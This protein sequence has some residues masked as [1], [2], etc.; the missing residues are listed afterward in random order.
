[1]FE[2]LDDLE[3]ASWKL[4]VQQISF[5]AVTESLVIALVILLQL[6]YSTYIK[7]RAGDG[8]LHLAKTKVLGS[9]F[10]LPDDEYL[11]FSKS[12][13]LVN[14]LFSGLT[15][16]L[17]ILKTQ[18]LDVDSW[19]IQL[20]IV[21]TAFF[22]LHFLVNLVRSEFSWDYV[23]SCSG[24]IDVF[25]IVVI[26]VQNTH[27]H[28]W[29]SWS[30]FRMY[31][32]YSNYATL[33]WLGWNP[34]N[35]HEIR[36]HLTLSVFKF[37]AV[38]VIMSGSVFVVEVLGDID[39][40]DEKMIRVRMGHVSFYSIF[41]MV[42]ITVSTVG[43][44]DLSPT[45]LLGRFL[46]MGCIIYGV[47][48]FSRESAN[49]V[50]IRN[51]AN[52]GSGHY[53][54]RHKGKLRHV[55]V[56]GDALESNSTIELEM[57]LQELFDYRKLESSKKDSKGFVAALD[58]VFLSRSA[59]SSALQALLNKRATY[60]S[61]VHL[62]QGSVFS[63]NDLRRCKFKSCS[64]FFVL[65]SMNCSNPDETDERGILMTAAMLKM[66]PAT[67]FQLVLLR[68]HSRMLAKRFNIPQVNCFAMYEFKANLLAQGVRCPGLSTILFHLGKA[69][70]DLNISKRLLDAHPW[71]SEYKEGALHQVIATLLRD[72]YCG[73]T[74]LECALKVYE[75][76][77]ALLIAFSLQGR[78]VT[79]PGKA[80]TVTSSTVVYLIAKSKDQVE[81]IVQPGEDWKDAFG[82]LVRDQQ[83]SR[84]P[85]PLFKE[86]RPS[87]RPARVDDTAARVAPLPGEVAPS[88][89]EGVVK[90]RNSTWDLKLQSASTFSSFTLHNLDD[91]SGSVNLKS[92]FTEED[93]G[94]GAELRA[95]H[96]LQMLVTKVDKQ[97]KV[98]QAVQA[99]EA[100]GEK[101]KERREKAIFPALMMSTRG[102]I[103]VLATGKLL[104]QQIAAF[105]RPLRSKAIL[106]WREIVVVSKHELPKDMP[107]FR[108]VHYIN[109]DP[110]DFH[111]LAL[112][113]VEDAFKIVIL[114][115]YRP[116]S[117]PHL[118]DQNTVLCNG[119]VESYL[120]Q[121]PQSSA[122][123][124]TVLSNP[125]SIKQL[126]QTMHRESHPEELPRF[127]DMKGFS[128]SNLEHM[129]SMF[130]PKKQLDVLPPSLHPQ[131]VSGESM[132]LTQMM[133]W[134]ASEFHTPG[135]VQLMEALMSPENGDGGMMPSMLWMMHASQLPE[136]STWDQ[137]ATRCMSQGAI[138]IAAHRSMCI[139]DLGPSQSEGTG[140]FV[141]TNPSPDMLLW[142]GRKCRSQEQPAPPPSIWRLPSAASD[143]SDSAKD[144]YNA[145][146]CGVDSLRYLILST[147]RLRGG[148]GHGRTGGGL[149]VPLRGTGP[150]NVSGSY[151]DRGKVESR[152]V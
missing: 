140:S 27:Q 132:V 102:H 98:L 145:C 52:R 60:A 44:G 71:I 31:S 117:E 45:T 104:E 125:H 4:V 5:F 100:A 113:A 33:V 43:Y 70:Q 138:P 64:M 118:M 123:I 47:V 130:V 50:A 144:R 49:I 88:Q 39:G 24:V 97:V 135:F 12:L 59:P 34:L 101:A 66:F 25:T 48:F 149:P 9:K 46:I 152:Q 96:A 115:A 62:L 126:A 134:V 142:P 80:V 56:V 92:R 22:T 41:Y 17:W 3:E 129:G 68:P 29:L 114:D 8:A 86:K 74:F 143:G 75:K 54:S 95:K 150:A 83:T 13:S 94:R 79:N 141:M 42:M 77:R 120:N 136:C 7:T 121:F 15:V 2:G 78:I 105:I 151:V 23:L 148:P 133:G 18:R 109:A 103:V 147:L 131:F 72:E 99:L 108:G 57:V 30:Y 6:F 28:A 67:P 85:M 128:M 84:R 127:L 1:M 122:S 32:M 107:T 35:H 112:A 40:F 55:V 51:E 146:A 61:H 91:M 89:S 87:I 26:L 116:H 111:G 139:D 81:S 76:T 93:R 119:V 53:Q 20:E 10:Q 82:A 73:V 14:V 69:P 58:V 19:V 90:H 137:L 63:E 106:I 11:W 21:T 36:Q 65:P 38:L 110:M 37:F 124:N 16:A